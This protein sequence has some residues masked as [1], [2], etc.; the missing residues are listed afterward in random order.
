MKTAT[1][2]MI[3]LKFLELGYFGNTANNVS[4]NN[5]TGASR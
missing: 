5:L 2:I 4:E 1:F 3:S